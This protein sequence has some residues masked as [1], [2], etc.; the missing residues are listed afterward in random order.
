M[1]GCHD[2]GFTFAGSIPGVSGAEIRLVDANGK[3]FSVY[4]GPGGNFYATTPW[5][6]PAKVGVRNGS[7]KSV[8]STTLQSANGGCNGCHASGGET[9]PISL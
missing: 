6:G 9:T 5:T 1:S 3:A 7:G 8:M 2:H 4:S